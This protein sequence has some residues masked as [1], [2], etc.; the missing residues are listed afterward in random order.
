MKQEI[1]RKVKKMKREEMARVNLLVTRAMACDP[2]LRRERERVA[3]EK[4]EKEEAKKLEETKKSESE[5]RERE[6]VELEM[7]KKKSEAGK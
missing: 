5:K 3:M 2:R 7:A 6:K 1:D 4:R